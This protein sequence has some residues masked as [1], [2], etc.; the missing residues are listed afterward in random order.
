[1]REAEEVEELNG[2]H[3]RD[4]QVDGM[5]NQRNGISR[6]HGKWYSKRFTHR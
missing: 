1:M 5:S 4:S 6:N 2:A 3:P